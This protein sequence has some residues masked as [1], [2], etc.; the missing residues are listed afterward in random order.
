VVYDTVWPM[1]HVLL[2]RVVALLTLCCTLGGYRLGSDTRGVPMVPSSGCRHYMYM[3][4][5]KVYLGCITAGSSSIQ[6]YYTKGTVSYTVLYRLLCRW[7]LMMGN[8]G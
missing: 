7:V 2:Y 4:N 8:R 1:L 6:V 5:G 3:L